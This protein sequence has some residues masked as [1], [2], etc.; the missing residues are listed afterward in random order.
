MF[1]EMLGDGVPRSDLE[2]VSSPVGLEIG[3]RSDGEIAVSIAAELL[4][5][6]GT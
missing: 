3:S 2:R 1:A 4:K 6:E 5:V